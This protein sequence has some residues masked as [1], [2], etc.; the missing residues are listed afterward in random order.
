MDSFRDAKKIIQVLQDEGY[1]AYFAG[2]WVR[3]YLLGHP[4][5]DIDI[6]TDAPLPVILDLFPRTQLVGMVFGVVIVQMNGHNYEVATFRKD[7]SYSNGRSPDR[8]EKATPEEDAE[9][10]D[11]TINGMFYDPL[12]DKVYDYVGGMEDL[13]KG[14]V[15]AIG[16]PFDRFQEDRLRMIRAVR[17]SSR[18]NYRLDPDTEE[19]IREYAYSL[20]PSVAA[21]R[22]YQE[23][24]KMADYPHFDT[25]LNDLFRLNLLG[26]II[27]Q[28]KNIHLH[29]F[30]EKTAHFERFPD[31]TPMIVYLRETFKH[32]PLK[33]QLD[34]CE[35]L[36]ATVKDRELVAYLGREE[37]LL[38]GKRSDHDWAHFYANPSHIYALAAGHETALPHEER[39]KRLQDPIRRI[40]EKRPLLTSRHL[41]EAG[42]A[43]G[44]DMGRLLKEGEKMHINNDLNSAEEILEELKKSKGWP[45]SKK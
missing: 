26:E 38:A 20:F 14:L 8:I 42:I 27:P 24:S 29:E 6:A 31:G 4:S 7:V 21:E 45:C 23:L 19:A 34:I 39:K 5:S 3:D 18:F 37:P 12:A 33:E 28:L 17:F 40:R 2:G 13:K 16:N 36:K 1:T 15:K 35:N 11:F 41:M 25:C 32:L 30:R 10:R 44:V 22:I 43:P 9:R